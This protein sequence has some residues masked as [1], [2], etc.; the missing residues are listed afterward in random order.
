MLQIMRKPQ[1]ISV[2][3]ACSMPGGEGM[4]GCEGDGRVS[5]YQGPISLFYML[6]S[7][8]LTCHFLE[9]MDGNRDTEQHIPTTQSKGS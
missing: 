7:A 6:H 4:V 2:Q 9:R 5:L 1:K 8:P 3:C